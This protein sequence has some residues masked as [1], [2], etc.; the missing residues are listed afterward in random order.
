MSTAIAVENS[1][2]SL[3]IPLGSYLKKIALHEFYIKD[4]YF[5]S[6]ITA[7]PR[8][9]FKQ[10]E[11]I[12]TPYD[13]WLSG[14]DV[15]KVNL[16]MLACD[17][18]QKKDPVNIADFL[19]SSLVPYGNYVDNCI[20][21][22]RSRENNSSFL[23]SS[24]FTPESRFRLRM[25]KL[26][27]TDCTNRSLSNNNGYLE[28]LDAPV[29]SRKVLSGSYLDSCMITRTYYYEESQKLETYCSG[30]TLS[31]QVTN[32]C[33]GEGKDIIYDNGVVLCVETPSRQV[34]SHQASPYLPPGNYLISC[35]RAAFYP[36]L[37]SNGQGKL[38]A[39]C[40]NNNK[41]MVPTFMEDSE[42]RCRMDQLGYVSNIDGEL[43]CD[44][45]IPFNN[46]DPTQG[47]DLTPH[48]QCN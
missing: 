48:F 24:C 9:D 25:N 33:L 29:D 10:E 27:I 36:C 5:H 26:D 39:E 20:G 41:D 15:K 7:R 30:K 17:L 22:L 46:E 12:T 31:L 32:E 37:G 3:L 21:T 19:Y 47:T 38:V 40:K 43:V 45:D 13:C 44:P 18:S 35:T 16:H 42:T 4:N 11:N 23:Y 14:Y 6:T 28:C 8:L 2:P 34:L 1:Q